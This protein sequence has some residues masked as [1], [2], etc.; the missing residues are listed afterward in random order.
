MGR[1]WPW[2]RSRPTPAPAPAP[3]QGDATVAAPREP[4]ALGSDF[5]A[6]RALAAAHL[7]PDVAQVWLGHLRPAV[8]L[9]SAAASDPVIARLG[10]T[11]VVPE[12][13]EWPVW[14]GHG[15]LAF[16]GEV[17]L[18]ALHA[19]GLPLDVAL[20]SSGRLLAF[21]FDG[22]YDDFAGIVG[23]WDPETLAGA[24]LVHVREAREECAAVATPPRVEE[25]G[26]QALTGRSTLTFAG[27]EHPALVRAFGA[28]GLPHR[29]WMA[30]PVNGEAFGQALW[31]LRAG[32]PLHQ[33]GGWA[34]PQQGPV[35]AEVAHAAPDQAFTFG[36]TEQPGR[37]DD[38]LA[39]SLLLQIDSDDASA[40]MWGDVGTLYWLGRP[41][42]DEDPLATVSFTWQCS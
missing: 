34:D 37:V 2:Q 12:G 3:A 28:E 24:R 14:E 25:F 11:P 26:E 19:A 15:P 18:D 27:W 8:R 36:A 13:F 7:P 41:G 42:G 30:H 23:T 16:I 40:M 39:W 38:V 4:E 29:E 6:M 22:S 35:E 33:I 32:Q 17:D 9:H 31:D 1:R 5:E 10:G 21:Y 20:P